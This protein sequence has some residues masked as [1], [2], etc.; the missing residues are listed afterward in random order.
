MAGTGDHW[1]GGHGSSSPIAR[2]VR[3]D[4]GVRRAWRND[5]IAQVE[6]LKS[7]TAVEDRTS[8][9]MAA[10]YPRHEK[11]ESPPNGKYASL[12]W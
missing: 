2:Q 1:H 8:L 3:L 9:R 6:M 10:T 11:G 12:L 5:L 7:D 4:A